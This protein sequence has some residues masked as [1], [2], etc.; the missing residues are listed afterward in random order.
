MNL[1]FWIKGWQLAAV[2][3]FPCAVGAAPFAYIGG[4]GQLTVLDTA[5][6]SIVSTVPIVS[7]CAVGIAVNG[8]GTRVYVGCPF[9]FKVSV[10]DTGSNTVVASVPLGNGA[11]GIAVNDAG[12]RVYAAIPTSNVVS[13]IDTAS[14]S[15][16]T[17]VAVGANPDGLAVDPSGSRVYVAN[18][19][20]NNVSVIDTTSNTVVATIAVGS[21]PLAVAV[22][23][24]GTRAFV[25][26]SQSNSVSVI[27]T[28]TNTVV[29]TVPVGSAPSGVAGPTGVAVNPAG[30]R[31]YVVDNHANSASVIDTA[32][33]AV[34]ATV[35][36]G[37][38]PLGVALNPEGTRA[39]VPG[40][41][42]NNISVI[43]TASNAVIATVAGGIGCCLAFGQFIMPA[44]GAGAFDLN[45]HGLT[46]SWY[47]P[48]TNGQGFEVE[49]F[50]DMV[51]PGTGAT[52]VSWFTFDTVAGGASHQR[53]YTLSGNMVSG[54]PNAALTIYQNTGGNFNSPPTTNGVVVGTAT[55]SFDTCGSGHLSYTFT[56][57][58]ARAGVI[59]LTRITQNVTCST[60]GTRPT[61]A[62][63]AFSGNWYNAATN[64]QGFTAEVN[65]LNGALFMPW[66]TYA[67]GGAGAGAAGQRWYTASGAFAPGSRSIP[68]DLYE[69]T[70][71][72]FDMPTVPAPASVKVGTGTL[73]FQSCSTATLNFNFTGGSSSGSSGTIALTRIGPVPPGCAF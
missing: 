63:F 40:A 57:G 13:V 33:N 59:P 30:T 46:G 37:A 31:V 28:A 53:W 71:G 48:A 51:A 42:S 2:A 58:S 52:Q 43:D 16:I 15:V 6:N 8:S 19:H 41:D 12:T 11:D 4:T 60:T 5:T 25:T 1:G 66:Y 24:A 3:L 10:V 44:A 20:S 65:P 56:D 27:D 9:V 72:V 35:A 36:V 32:T 22:N 47:E 64:G 67:P 50:P 68:V 69:T 39:Y 34:V 7:T 61:N 73:A 26:N 38:N 55:L 29:A 62:D 17:N 21:F 23:R 49:V 70:G 18:L 45:Q 54:Q 14:N